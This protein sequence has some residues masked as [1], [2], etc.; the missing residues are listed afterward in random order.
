MG[1]ITGPTPTVQIYIEF[2]EATGN[3]S[4]ATNRPISYP[5]MNRMLGTVIVGAAMQAQQQLE[6]GKKPEEV[7]IHFPAK[8]GTNSGQNGGTEGGNDGN[9][10][11]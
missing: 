3:T 5:A 1:L 4:F 2:D 6:K 7:L 10:A 8:D 9:K 11:S